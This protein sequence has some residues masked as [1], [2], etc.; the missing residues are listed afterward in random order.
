MLSLV[1]S[2][3]DFI[4]IEEVIVNSNTFFNLISKNKEKFTTEE[5]AE[6]ITNT[7]NIGAERFLVKDNNEF[8][9][10]LEYLLF[11]PN[12]QSTWLGLLLIKKKFQNQGYGLKSLQLFNELMKEKGIAKY[13]IGVISENTPAHHFWN[14]NGFV[15]IDST[16]NDDQK[17]II[18]YEKNI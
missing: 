4:E 17:E 10:I 11:N 12:D 1:R 7:K 9:G 14:K 8:V 3:I 5:I 6:E 18:I 15:K 16:I 13:R 2:S